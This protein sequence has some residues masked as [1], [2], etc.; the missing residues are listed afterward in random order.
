M[1]SVGALV[2]EVSGFL[3]VASAFQIQSNNPVFQATDKTGC[4]SV[5]FNTAGAPVVIHNCDAEDS[6]L[7]DWD[8]NRFTRQNAPPQPLKIFGDKCLDVKDGVNADGAKLQIWTWVDG[9]TNQ[10][11]ISATDFTFQWAGTNKCVDFTNGNIEDGTQLQLWTCDPNNPNQKWTANPVVSQPPP[12]QSTGRHLLASGGKQHITSQCM[13][14]SSNTDGA[15]VALAACV[16]PEPT[17]PEGNISPR[18]GLSVRSR[19]S[20]ERNASTFEVETVRTGIRCR[21]GRALRGI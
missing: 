2:L 5:Y 10:L 7:H 3:V 18:P 15:R 20:T 6:V 4:I 14:A 8:F 13:T 16:I 11:W 19:H 21:S 17:F 1:V 9:N 12:S